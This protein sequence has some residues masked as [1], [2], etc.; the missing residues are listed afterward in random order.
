MKN[1]IVITMAGR[2]SRFKKVGYKVP[3]Y[4]IIVHDKYL[5]DW[6][7]NSLD[8]FLLD[9]Y[10][11]IFICLK[12]N[13]SREFIN[14]R[15]YK[16]GIKDFHIIELDKITDGQA[17]TAYLANYNWI[18]DNPLLIYNIDTYTNPSFLNPKFIREDSEGWIPCFNVEG[19][20]WSFVEIDSQ[21]WAKNVKE[22][23]RIS[24]NASIGLYWFKSARFFE[25]IYEEFFVSEKNL[26][27]GEKYIAP[28]YQHII[29][30]NRKVS[31]TNVPIDHVH[32][33]G[34]PN[35]LNAFMKLDKS[36]IK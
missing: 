36:I 6:S 9:N 2:G 27:N 19:D 21:G 1:N 18:I 35:E 13:K 14:Q 12:E 5:F 15:C 3:K 22:K 10:N 17:T 31:I 24:N 25:E 16:M 29:D 26:V 7:M 28:M 11:L 33:L 34:T 32:V 30:K 23:K 8:N 4:E 20:H